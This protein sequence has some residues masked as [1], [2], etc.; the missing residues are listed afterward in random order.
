VCRDAW[1]NT[2]ETGVLLD[3]ARNFVPISDISLLLHTM[4]SVK[5]NVLH[6]HL[7]DDQ[8]H[9]TPLNPF[10]SV[11]HMHPSP[12]VSHLH[13]SPS[14]SHAIPQAFAFASASCPEF[15][16]SDPLLRAKQYSPADLRS[17]VDTAAGLGI[18]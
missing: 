14:V 4:A 16:L 18:R 1:R 15:T 7:T 17:I 11:S 6:M 2:H 10:P 9:L 12:S 5:L 8:V 13:P 3:V